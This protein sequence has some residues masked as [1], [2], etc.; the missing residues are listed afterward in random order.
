MII[1]LLAVDDDKT[2]TDFVKAIFL[3]VPGYRVETA[4]TGRH[5][6]KMIG[7]TAPDALLLDWNLP[8]ISGFEI[9]Q[10]LR[11][12]LKTRDLPILMLTAEARINKKVNALD[13]GADDY[14]VKPFNVEELKARTKALIRRK[15]PWLVQSQPLQ[16]GDMEMDPAGLKVFIKGK[17]ADFTPMEFNI[18][19]MLAINAGHVVQ[20]RYIELRVLG[21]EEFSRSLDVHLSRIR[22]KL[23]PSHARRIET[24]RGLGYVFT[25]E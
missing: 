11:R 9:C 25:S 21:K 20:R 1:N 4:D 23:G 15:L 3:H 10:I 16:F 24:A 19:Y 14:L 22:E 5:A 12:D 8:D 17:D 7:Q 6:L 18:L 13:Q 2:V